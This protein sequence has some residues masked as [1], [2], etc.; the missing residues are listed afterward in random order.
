MILTLGCRNHELA[1]SDCQLLCLYLEYKIVPYE[2]T[3]APKCP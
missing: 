3:L 2:T 1:V